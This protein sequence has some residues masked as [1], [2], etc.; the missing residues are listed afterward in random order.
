MP[1]MRRNNQ[2]GR[3]GLGA[4]VIVWV[5]RTWAARPSRGDYDAATDVVVSSFSE[6]SMAF[7]TI[8]KGIMLMAS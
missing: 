7:T 4:S 3:S 2:S 6:S 5:G 8:S 1:F